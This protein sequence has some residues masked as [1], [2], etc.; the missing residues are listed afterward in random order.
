MNIKLKGP[1]AHSYI[2]EMLAKTKSKF[3]I[4][5]D[6]ISNKNSV[7]ER[8]KIMNETDNKNFKLEK[9]IQKIRTGKKLTASELEYLRNERPDLYQQLINADK[10]V[11]QLKQSLKSCHSKEE[12]QNVINA[13]LTPLKK[14]FSE[15]GEYK[16]Q[17]YMEAYLEFKKSADY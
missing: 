6:N 17:A 4:N 7:E 5:N 13:A 8:N 12:A 10:G 15:I 3:V 2:K 16:R 9:I 11:Q 14:D 1:L